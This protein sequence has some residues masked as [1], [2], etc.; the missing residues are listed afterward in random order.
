MM[1]STTFVSLKSTNDIFLPFRV[2]LVVSACIASTMG[3]V[4]I[5]VIF[6][7]SKREIKNKRSNRCRVIDIIIASIAIAALGRSLLLGP[8]Q[9]ACFTQGEWPFGDSMCQLQAYIEAMLR[10]AVIWYL[11]LL[12]IERYT[13]HIM[14]HE[15]LATFSPLTVNIILLGILLIV[16]VQV[17]AP[18]YG[19]GKYEYIHDTGL[20]GTATTSTFGCSYAL[21]LFLSLTMPPLSVIMVNGVLLSYQMCK[22]SKAQETTKR[23]MSCGNSRILSSEKEIPS[24]VAFMVLF[25]VMSIPRCITDVVIMCSETYHLLS[26]FIFSIYFLD[27]LTSVLLPV[28]CFSMHP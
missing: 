21:Y 19:W 14:P 20:C 17:T 2:V 18:L 25:V 27:S 3:N 6:S 24:L 15:Y 28:L 22:K 9:T 11:S 26:P 10:N 7:A 12:S 4:V 23:S 1:N 8:L 5:L 13:K 16:I